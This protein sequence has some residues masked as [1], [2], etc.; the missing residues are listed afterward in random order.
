MDLAQGWVHDCP[1]ADAAEE[2]PLGEQLVVCGDDCPAAHAEALGEG[3][4][5]WYGLAGDD[6][7]VPD[8]CAELV[9]ELAWQGPR[10]GAIDGQRQGDIARSPHHGSL[11]V[12][13]LSY[14]PALVL[15][16]YAWFDAWCD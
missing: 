8:R 2:V 11:M 9:G 5:R 4:A 14:I 6:E 3:S 15:D 12:H 16:H 13:S 1:V 7:A 10:I